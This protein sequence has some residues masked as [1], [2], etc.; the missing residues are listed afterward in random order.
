MNIKCHYCQKEFTPRRKNNVYC[1]PTC[2]KRAS[3]KRTGSYYK[4][5]KNRSWR[6]AGIKITLDE[7]H[8]IFNKQNGVCL[9]CG[10]ASNKLLAVDHDHLTGKIRGLLCSKCNIGLGC[11]NDDI[12][13]LQMAIS[14]LTK[15]TSNNTNL[16]GLK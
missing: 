4:C 9:I 7:Y 13:L 5:N 15:V 6:D 16:V 8:Q 10:K 3:S 11:F 2:E 1:K 14:Y 12:T